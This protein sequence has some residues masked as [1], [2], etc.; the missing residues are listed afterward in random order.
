MFNFPYNKIPKFPLH[1]TISAPISTVASGFIT[2][3][4][5]ILHKNIANR[6]N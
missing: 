1:L 6:E 3:T 4:K 5:P 2:A